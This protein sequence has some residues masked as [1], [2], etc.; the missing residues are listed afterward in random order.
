MGI[1]GDTLSIVDKRLMVNGQPSE[2]FE[3]IEQNYVVEARER[4]RLSPTRVRA[5][6]ANILQSREERYIMNMTDEVAGR[7]GSWAEVVNVHPYVL[8]DTHNDF[9]RQPFTFA[10]GF[11]GNHHHMDPMVIPFAGQ[12]VTLTSDNWHHYRDILVRFEGNEVQRDGDEFVI[13]GVETNEYTIQQD[14]YFMMGDS[15]DNSEDSRFWGY[16]PED[17]VVGRAFLIYFS[18]D[19]DRFLPRVS[20][21]FNLI[22]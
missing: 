1:A 13:N 16:V 10:S 5:A 7:I 22:H 14:Y 17:H 6:G 3:T 19:S 2:G 15:R 4:L 9:A 21:M 8:P 11:T 12:T 18:W 20:R